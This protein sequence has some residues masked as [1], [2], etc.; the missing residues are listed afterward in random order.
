MVRKTR[1][2]TALIYFGGIKIFY[3]FIRIGTYRFS[4]KMSDILKSI[5]Y[6]LRVYLTVETQ[7]FRKNI[8]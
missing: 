2:N 7:T 4:F 5:F 6:L 3:G 8:K 1:I